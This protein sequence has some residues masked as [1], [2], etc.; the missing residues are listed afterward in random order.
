MFR[1]FFKSFDWHKLYANCELVKWD[2]KQNVNGDW[3]FTEWE[4]DKEFYKVISSSERNTYYRKEDD[5]IIKVEEI[6]E[7][8]VKA[9]ETN[10]EYYAKQ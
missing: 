10:E 3:E 7:E 2:Y 4:W 9:D 1:V 8:D 6:T 5:S